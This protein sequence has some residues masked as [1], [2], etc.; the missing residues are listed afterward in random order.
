MLQISNLH[1]HNTSLKNKNNKEYLKFLLAEFHMFIFYNAAVSK[2]K[3][4]LGP[5]IILFTEDIKIWMIQLD[6]L[7]IFVTLQLKKHQC[8]VLEE[9]IE[10]CP[11]LLFP[12]NYC[13]KGR[14]KLSL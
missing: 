13:Q 2:K 1:S 11:F 8:D 5:S 7:E 4:Y 14:R 3:I 6:I 9:D 10:L 12:T